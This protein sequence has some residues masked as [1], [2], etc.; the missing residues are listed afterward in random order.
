MGQEID[1]L[2]YHYSFLSV[3]VCYE[4]MDSISHLI[5]TFL[6]CETCG[7]EAGDKIVGLS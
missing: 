2:A 6:N 1:L 3:D 5:K 4:V 7:K